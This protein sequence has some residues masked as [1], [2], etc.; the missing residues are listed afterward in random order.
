RPQDAV[1]PAREADAPG[2]GANGEQRPR[3]VRR[4]AVTG[5]V[6]DRKPLPRGREDDL[7]RDDE[8]RQSYGVHLRAGDV[9][10]AR[11][12]RTDDVLDGDGARRRAYL[13]EALR[14]LARRAARRVGLA[15]AR[16]VDDLPRREMPRRIG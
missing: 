4:R 8:A 10:P 14:E 13:A 6:A 1:E 11:L 9:G 12:A 15:R 5:V 3:H 2:D 7:G 16:V